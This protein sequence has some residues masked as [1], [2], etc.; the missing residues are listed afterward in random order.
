MSDEILLYEVLTALNDWLIF[1][2][3][4]SLNDYSLRD[5]P[6]P[7]DC[8]RPSIL[9]VC[10]RNVSNGSFRNDEVAVSVI[11]TL[12]HRILYFN[13]QFSDDIIKTVR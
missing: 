9:L 6:E 10:S 1:E 5:D 3:Q 7:N 2:P 13:V 11:S 4:Q 12:V 8:R